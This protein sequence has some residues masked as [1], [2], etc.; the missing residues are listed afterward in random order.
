MP[1]EHGLHFNWYHRYWHD[2]PE[3]CETVYGVAEAHA[4]YLGYEVNRRFP[5]V[6]PRVECE[7][8]P[9]D[10]ETIGPVVRVKLSVLRRTGKH[11][12]KPEYE[13]LYVDVERRPGGKFRVKA[14]SH[15]SF[16]KNLR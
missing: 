16:D 11:R 8:P 4:R 12:S 1:T 5:D 6:I 9:G 14:S 15:S 2:W 7:P 3:V 13:R 10:L